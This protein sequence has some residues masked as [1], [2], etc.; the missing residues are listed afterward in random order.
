MARMTNREKQLKASFYM[1]NDLIK[2][3]L[4]QPE[5]I[6]TLRDR[7]EEAIA[8]GMAEICAGLFGSDQDVMKLLNEGKEIVDNKRSEEKDKG[9][10]R[11]LA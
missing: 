10:N 2:I 7:F 3:M 1:V 4:N 6:E 5:L 8:L 11:A 9:L